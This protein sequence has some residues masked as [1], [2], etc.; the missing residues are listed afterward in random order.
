M[1]HNIIIIQKHDNQY[2]FLNCQYWLLNNLFD[3]LSAFL[4]FSSEYMAHM[5]YMKDYSL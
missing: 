2:N 4:C 5:S 3:S 1:K